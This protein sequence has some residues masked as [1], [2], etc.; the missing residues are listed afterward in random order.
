MKKNYDN[1]K[2]LVASLLKNDQDILDA[3]AYIKE[4]YNVD[5]IYDNNNDVF[6]MWGA[7]NL[8]EAYNYVRS[9]ISEDMLDIALE[10]PIDI[11]LVEKQETVFVVYYEDGTMLNYFYTKEEAEAAKK[12]LQTQSPINKPFIKEEP[13][14][15]F[16]KK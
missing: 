14:K 8:P 11:T 16:V 3:S 10:E 6:Y 2:N 7:E 1:E 9:K 5:C 12:D 4:N 15:N 13:L